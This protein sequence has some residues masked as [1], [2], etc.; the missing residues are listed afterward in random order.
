MTRRIT[1]ALLLPVALATATAEPEPP[2]AAPAAPPEADPL[3]TIG[4]AGLQE[5]FR[6]LR[7]KYIQKEDLTPLE[8]NRAALQ[9]V[10]DRLEFGADLVSGPLPD[11][12]FSPVFRGEDIDRG[13][14]FGFDNVVWLALEGLR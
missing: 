7:S 3:D 11:P 14:G 2:E 12:R 13:I 6:I 9:G 8:I 4:M 1:A 5:A 10:V